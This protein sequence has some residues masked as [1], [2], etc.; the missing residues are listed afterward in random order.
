MP[1][2][3]VLKLLKKAMVKHQDTNRFLLDGFPRSVEQAQCF[4]RDIAEAAWGLFVFGHHRWR[5]RACS[6]FQN[7][8]QLSNMAQFKGFALPVPRPQDMLKMSEYVR[9]MSGCHISNA[10]LPC[11]QVSFLLYLEA[12]H[13]TMKQRIQGRAAS[14]PGRVDDNDETVKK[15]LEVFD[16]QTVPLVNYYGPIGKLRRANAETLEPKGWLGELA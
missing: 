5:Y 8:K 11:W 16:S 12:S 3:V 13:E 15:R 10:C 4:E 14:N 9:M 2:E 1:D 6:D 7:L